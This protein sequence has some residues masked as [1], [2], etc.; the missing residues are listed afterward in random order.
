MIFP[1]TPPKDSPVDLWTLQNELIEIVENL[2]GAR[3]RTKI[4][5]QP[6]FKAN[7]PYLI[8]SF[9][10]DGAWSCLSLNAADYW[11]TA[12]YE[13]AHETVHL[14]N[15]VAGHTNWLEEGV[16]VAFSIIAL[17]NYRIPVQRPIAGA[18][19][20]ALALVEE[21]PGGPMHFARIVREY[22]GTLGNVTLENLL[23]IAPAHDE[24]KLR[25]LA[26]LCIPR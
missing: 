6:T 25:K 20:E 18:Y 1:P 16:A 3:D 13:M 22:A 15:H 21:L 23:E 7:G 10:G 12:V 14:L 5:Y 4:I 24:E 11:P 26:S 19:S 8:N 17:E 9:N 2:M